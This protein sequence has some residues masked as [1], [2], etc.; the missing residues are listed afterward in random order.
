MTGEAEDENRPNNLWQPLPGDHGARGRFGE[1]LYE[2][3]ELTA[4]GI[5]LAGLAWLARPRPVQGRR[6]A[7]GTASM[8]L[9]A[10]IA[11][12]PLF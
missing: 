10:Y 1:E 5:G 6:H 11:I 2:S 7:S 8:I 3:S 4:A 9:L 12:N